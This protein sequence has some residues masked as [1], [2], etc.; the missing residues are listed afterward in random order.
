MVGFELLKAPGNGGLKNWALFR[1]EVGV[2]RCEQNVSCLVQSSL[3][4][5]DKGTLGMGRIRL[6]WESKA[7]LVWKVHRLA[8]WL[9]T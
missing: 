3:V 4:W 2:I 9:A 7:C 1:M 6:G 5:P 8:R